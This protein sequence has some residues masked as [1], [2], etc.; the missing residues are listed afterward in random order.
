MGSQNKS[1]IFQKTLHD[2][3]VYF[4]IE[5]EIHQRDKRKREVGQ[6]DRDLE[7]ALD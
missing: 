6:Y 2:L 5:K 3:Q 1:E 4:A 7:W